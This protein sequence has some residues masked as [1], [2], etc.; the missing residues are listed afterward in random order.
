MSRKVGNVLRSGGPAVAILLAACAQA[1]PPASTGP[2]ADATPKQPVQSVLFVGNSFTYGGHSAA[3]KYRS[4]IVT[5]LNGDGVGGVPALFKLFTKEA[6]LNYAVSLE[7]DGGKTLGW[8][9]EHKR[10][11]LDRPWNHVVLQDLS[12]FTRNHPGDPATLIA[13]ARKF[14]S[15]FEARNA[16]VD[17]SL[18]STWSRPD[19][20]YLSNG[21]WHGQPITH[22][23]RDIREG[24][25]AAKVAI[26]GIGR[27][28]PVGQGFNC[29]IE[30]GL[31]DAN[32][33][34]GLDA[35]KID[36]WTY[37]H[38][39]AS[40]AGYYLEALIIFADITGQD[41]RRFGEKE[42]AAS[43]LGISPAHAARLQQIAWQA[44]TSD[45]R[46]DRDPK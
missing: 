6:G 18:L 8:H 33:Y 44:S 28:H 25:D 19:Q 15:M 13:S 14:A 39:H 22:M 34:D 5:D 27:V 29:A 40:A 7:T 10:T 24:Y 23:A 38:Y 1:A 3:W 35:G 46:C 20:T 11:L 36:L 45:G 42:T 41:P 26:P 30:S 9:W 21:H 4:D 17:I 32:P 37:D 43:E 12:T 2:S 31:A 16:G